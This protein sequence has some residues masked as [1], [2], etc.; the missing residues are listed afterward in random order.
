MLNEKQRKTL[1]A[2]ICEV[3]AL[4]VTSQP[5]A[6]WRGRTLQALQTAAAPD[7]I[8]LAQEYRDYARKVH[9]VEG[10]LEIDPDAVVSLGCEKGAYVQAWLW[11]DESEVFAHGR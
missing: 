4:N 2:L 3:R 6:S 9:N 1:E 5:Q 11:V 8:A 10:H 7:E